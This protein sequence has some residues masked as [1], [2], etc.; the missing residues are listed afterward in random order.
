EFAG[1]LGQCEEF[2]AQEQEEF[3]SAGG[4]WKSHV[5]FSRREAL[6]RNA[7]VEKRSRSATGAQRR[8]QGGQVELQRESAGGE[9]QRADCG[10]PGVGGDG[11]GRALCCTGNAAGTSGKRACDGGRRQGL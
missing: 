6:E 8:G 7:R 1:S 11:H 2:S 4:S 10:Q 9:S 3:A 5:G